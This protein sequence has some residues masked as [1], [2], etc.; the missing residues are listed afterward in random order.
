M[1][2][3]EEMTPNELAELTVLHTV[4]GVEQVTI[5]RDETYRTTEAGPLT[6]DVYY[7]PGA[8][9]GPRLPAVIIVYGYS[10]AGFPN[11]FGRLFKEMGPS[12]S[13]AKLIAASGMIAILYSNREP[14]TD[15]IAVVRYV[16]E[17]ASSL[18]IDGTR[19]GLW[20]ASAN[21]PVALWLLM[22]ADVPATCAALCC[23]Y[24][25]DVDGA[26]GVADIQKTYRFA[27]PA[28]VKSVDDVRKGVPLLIARS[29][30]DQ[31]PGL[32]ESLDNFVR[33]ALRC[34]LPLT[35]VNHADAPHGFDLFHDSE[36]TRAIIRQILGF[37]RFHLSA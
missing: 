10:D 36:T 8:A 31:F 16:R 1:K 5:R 21:V 13:W 29:G 17:R 30:Q 27:T 3:Q 24:M 14:A 20:S 23:G 11:V 15:A 7:P 12:V 6:L 9:A 28:A 33:G 34:N 32:N 37:L 18:G 35:L 26:T 19:I 2:K 22:Q 4:P 25:L